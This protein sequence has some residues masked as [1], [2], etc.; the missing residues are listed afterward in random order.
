LAG[1]SSVA[2]ALA[3]SPCPANVLVVPAKLMRGV[4]GRIDGGNRTAREVLDSSGHLAI[5]PDLFLASGR[6]DIRIGYRAEGE[7]GRDIG[8]LAVFFGRD[9]FDLD[10]IGPTANKTVEK[11]QSIVIPYRARN[12]RSRVHIWYG[13]SGTLCLSYLS[14][15]RTGS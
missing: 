6:Y 3:A 10:G 12:R 1:Y 13:G 8:R 14:V 2:I 15:E 9:W 4:V 7:P 5:G 11:V